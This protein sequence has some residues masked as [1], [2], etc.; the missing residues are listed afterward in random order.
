MSLKGPLECFVIYYDNPVKHL[1]QP[2]F[3]LYGTL[4]SNEIGCTVAYE[5]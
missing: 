5:C 2:L 1:T 4:L 3:S